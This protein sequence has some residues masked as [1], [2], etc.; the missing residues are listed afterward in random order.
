LVLLYGVFLAIASLYTGLRYGL[1]Y[2]PVLPLVF[3]ALQLSFG[4]G[5]LVGIF[6]SHE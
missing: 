3:A 6:K 4:T 1:K 5:F 2:L